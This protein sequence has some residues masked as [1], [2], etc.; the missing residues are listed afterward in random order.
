MKT[1]MAVTRYKIGELAR[2]AGLSVHGVRYYESQGLISKAARTSGGFRI[3]TE[4]DLERLLFIRQA[5]RFGLSLEE[6]RSVL[7]CSLKGL[8]PCCDLAVRL[9]ER[10]ILEFE[11]KITELQS[12]KRQIRRLLSKSSLMKKRSVPK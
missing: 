1:T 3:Y 6:I 5:Q 10:K 11:T 12:L 7:P 8:E 9:F 2:K 4:A